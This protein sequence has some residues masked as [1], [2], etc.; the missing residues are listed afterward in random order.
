MNSQRNWASNLNT[1]QKNLIHRVINKHKEL[2]VEMYPKFSKNRDNDS[3]KFWI[4]VGTSDMGNSWSPFVIGHQILIIMTNEFQ[5]SKAKGRYLNFE[6]CLKRAKILQKKCLIFNISHKT[7]KM[8]T[9]WLLCKL[10]VQISLINVE[11]S[12]SKH[13]HTVDVN[14]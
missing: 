7:Y 8:Y 11:L 12:L 14:Y 13:L 6:I 9:F 5:K 4:L 1:I 2:K 10:F 3:G